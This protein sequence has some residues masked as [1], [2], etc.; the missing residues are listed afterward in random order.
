M[1][2]LF[3]WLRRAIALVGSLVL[4]AVVAVLGALWLALPGGS[5]ESQIPGLSA[6]VGITID[7]DGIPRVRAASEAD[8]AAAL[9]WLHAR[10][11]M[12][13]MDLMRRAANWPNCSA[14]R[15]CRSTG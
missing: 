11:R 9:G 13:Q 2:S 7:D 4:L 15:R 5:R 1:H 14:R 3:R 6:P 12:F 8:G 10:E